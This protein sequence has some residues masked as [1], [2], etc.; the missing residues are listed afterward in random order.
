M[1]DLLEKIQAKEE[2]EYMVEYLDVFD[3]IATIFVYNDPSRYFNNNLELDMNLPNEND[4]N[5]NPNSSANSNDNTES[6]IASEE[7][8]DEVYPISSKKHSS[9]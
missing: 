8:H 2:T 9:L 5:V 7:L 1:A 4:D 3:Q 6:D